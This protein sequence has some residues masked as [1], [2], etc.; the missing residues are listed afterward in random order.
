MWRIVGISLG[1]VGMTVAGGMGL[2]FVHDSVFSN[3]TPV[4]AQVI[5]PAPVVKRIMSVRPEEALQKEAVVLA[6]ASA[7]IALPDIEY[8]V[9][10]PDTPRLAL[11]GSDGDAGTVT[12][13]AITEFPIISLRPKLRG[14]TPAVETRSARLSPSVTRR[15]GQRPRVQAE[16][17]RATPLPIRVTGQNPYRQPA[18][19]TQ[20]SLPPRVLIGVYR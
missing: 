15:V 9:V 17:Q 10:N 4:R 14:D 5:A 11:R 8:A 7:D 13:R 20:R 18:R 3:P 6:R 2:S 1:L 12:D 19:E 16:V